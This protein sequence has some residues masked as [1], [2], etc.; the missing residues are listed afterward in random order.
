[1]RIGSWTRYSLALLLA[2]ALTGCY[3]GHGGPYA[4]SAGLPMP[5]GL[6][7]LPAEG[8]LSVK[9]FMDDEVTPRF[10]DNDVDGGAASIT[11]EFAAPEGTHTFTVVFDYLDPE[12]VRE[13]SSPWELARWTSGPVEVMAGESLTLDVAES[14][15]VYADS[16]EDGV[17]NAAEL[18]DRTDPGDNTDPVDSGDPV[19]P[20]D[21]GDP[22]DP[23]D[24]VIIPP[25]GLWRGEAQG[26]VDS[27][28]I[29]VL[30]GGRI[31]MIAGELIYDGSYAVGTGGNFAGSVD[32]YSTQG[33]KL[34]TA[35]QAGITG[36]RLDE[37]SLALN[38]DAAGAAVQA[39][40]M[41]LAFDARYGRD[42][43]QALLANMWGISIDDPPY[44]LTFPIDS[45]GT[46]T[47][48]SDTDGCLYSGNLGVSDP[49]YNVYDVS[50]A[51]ADQTANACAPFTGAGYTGYATLVPDDDSMRIIVSN[52]AHALTFDLAKTG[53]LPEDK[54]RKPRPAPKD[55]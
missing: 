44:T 14:G 45:N 19:D 26:E 53:S 13:D 43:S 37:T 28:T 47:G 23:V 52:G 2:F 4:R 42:S 17:S 22:I 35:A 34:T 49:Q 12:F 27:G 31:T 7:S 51:L 18:S 21:P 33:D 50:L 3:Q 36:T 16:D 55:G 5:A 39:R 8:V 15:Y 20:G 40:A 48:A 38:V 1:M 6:L 11:L 41:S 24:P 25:D 54:P 46:L 29:A 9:V 32:I 30:H 10:S